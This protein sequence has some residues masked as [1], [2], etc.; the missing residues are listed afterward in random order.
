MDLATRPYR[1]DVP[2]IILHGAGARNQLPTLVQEL[3]G[4]RV[5]VVTDPGVLRLGFV[6]ELV[7]SLRQTGIDVAVFDAVEPDPTDINVE[8]G[9]EALLAHRSDLVVAIGGGSPIDVAKVIAVRPTNP[10]PLDAYMGIDRIANAGLPLI[11]VPTTSG[12]GSE[13]TKVA[14]ITDTA[15]QVK[16]MMLSSPL[17]PRAAVVDFELTMTMPKPLT[18][19]VGVDTLTHG[20][21][22]FVSKKANTL[23]D[24]LALQC[25]ALCSKHLR[26]AWDEPDNREAR[27]GMMMAATLGGMAFSNSS[28]A[29]VH[30]MSRPIGAIF[31]LAHGLS[32]AVLLPTVTRFSIHS[33]IDRYACVARTVGCVDASQPDV[34]ACHALVEWLEKLNRDV[35]LPRLS[36]CDGVSAKVFEASVEKMAAD[37]I[38]SGSPA[39]NP[40]VPTANEIVGL[41]REAW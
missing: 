14:V 2:S 40:R 23:T 5:L 41:Y 25:I 39:N 24:P 30:G 4:S 27:E 17:L 36:T 22:A 26:R 29:L 11:A 16:M 35:C 34:D 8:A 13:A 28:V 15:K 38:R 10:A 12:T 21:E 31:H 33:A 18:A 32:N 6:G 20:I 37:A 9:V 19:A 3:K 1:F 7:H